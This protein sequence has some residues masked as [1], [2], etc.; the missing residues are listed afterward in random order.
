MLGSEHARPS[1]RL[2]MPGIESAEQVFTC[3]NDPAL[4]VFIP[5]EPANLE[6]WKRRLAVA[7]HE[8][9][10]DNPEMRWLF[11]LAKDPA[12]CVVGIVEIGIFADGYAEI[13]FFTPKRFQNLG[14][15]KQFCRLA[16]VE[17]FTRFRIPGIYAS[18]NEQNAP[19][20]RVV[21]AL[22]FEPIR[23]NPKAEF[24]NGRWSDELIYFLPS[25]PNFPTL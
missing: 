11:R 23:S 21:R 5:D 3:L 22:G 19:A 24:V 2:T 12:E 14:Y 10:P 13:G 18:I 20:Q 7:S 9:S 4:Y 17:A 1:L 25:G 16:I 6:E 8:A 15:A